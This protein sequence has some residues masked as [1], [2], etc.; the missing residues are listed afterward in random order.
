M[1]EVPRGII[2]KEDFESFRRTLGAQ[3]PDTY[4]EWQYLG[5][6]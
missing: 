2:R 1:A 5:C 6:L 3:L 4:D